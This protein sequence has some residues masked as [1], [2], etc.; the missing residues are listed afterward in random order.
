MRALVALDCDPDWSDQQRLDHRLLTFAAGLAAVSGIE[1]H[2]GHAWS[3]LGENLIASKYGPE[4]T[5]PY[6]DLQF[7]Y[8]RECTAELVRAAAC[9]SV[10]TAVHHPKGEPGTAIPALA[11]AIGA[12]V[13][14]LGS[15]ARRGLAGLF[16]GSVAEA[17]LSRLGCSALVVKRLDFVSPVRPR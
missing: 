2:L 14:I 8:A 1:L 17:I 10:V 16:I 9:E 3:L 5:K 13:V 15:A 7:Q 6:L 12:D 11:E 4:G